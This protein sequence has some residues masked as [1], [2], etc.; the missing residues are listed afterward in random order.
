[1]LSA[2]YDQRL[3][4][5]E[6]RRR[7][8]FHYGAI[9]TGESL[10]DTHAQDLGNLFGLTHGGR[11]NIDSRNGKT[12]A[13]QAGY[14]ASADYWTN[15]YG[16]KVAGA[17][18]LATFWSDLQPKKGK[19]NSKNPDHFRR[20]LI[21]MTAGSS[22]GRIVTNNDM[23]RPCVLRLYGVSIITLLIMNEQIAQCCCPDPAILAKD[24][25]VYRSNYVS[26]DYRF[27]VTLPQG[28][29]GY[30]SVGPNPN[31]GFVAFL[32]GSSQSCIR[33]EVLYVNP[34]DTLK[35][36]R[37]ITEHKL[38]RGTDCSTISKRPTP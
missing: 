34:D 4:S 20:D 23:A 11:N 30:G 35:H 33:V 27:S 31:H 38:P 19:Y 5:K 15:N 6:N 25:L 29:I 16:S 8:E 9:S 18:D 26:V 21:C 3:A 2:F 14:Q 22:A 32:P 36:H 1:V 28:M 24:S 37:A 12:V 7:C 17:S 10:D 13:E